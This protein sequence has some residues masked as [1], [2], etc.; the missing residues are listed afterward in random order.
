MSCL[1]SVDAMCESDE[2]GT[3]HVCALRHVDVSASVDD[4]CERD[5]RGSNVH[6]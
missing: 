2:V 6:V 5:A 3:G 4:A 1:G